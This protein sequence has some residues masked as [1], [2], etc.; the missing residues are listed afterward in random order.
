MPPKR[1]KSIE[2]SVKPTARI[3]G[4]EERNIKK[5][6]DDQKKMEAIEIIKL[7]SSLAATLIEKHQHAAENK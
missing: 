5:S 3:G 7:L 2:E 4:A 1:Q 6:T